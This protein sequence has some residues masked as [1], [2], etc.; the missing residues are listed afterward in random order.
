MNHH[1]P[2]TGRIARAAARHPWR[3]LGLWVVLLAAAYFAAGTMSLTAN[4]G[5]AGTESKTAADLIDQRLRTQTPPEEYIVVESPTMTSSDAA[6][7]AFV[8]AL[9]PA[10]A[11]SRK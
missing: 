11:A 10:C 8:D 2:F 7:A 3:V 1:L 6:Y 9:L 5:T 4:P